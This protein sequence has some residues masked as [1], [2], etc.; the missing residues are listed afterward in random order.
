MCGLDVKLSKEGE[1]LL[2]SPYMFS[3]YDIHNYQVDKL[4]LTNVKRY[5]HDPV[6]TANSFDEEGYFKTGDIARR[7]GPY[8]FILGRAS[9]DSK[10]ILAMT[11]SNA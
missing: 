8:Y 9:I 11:F 5:L 3:K 1:I 7:E 10:G 2:K 6:A 4:D